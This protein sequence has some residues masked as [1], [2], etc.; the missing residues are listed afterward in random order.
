MSRDIDRILISTLP[1]SG[2]V[3]FFN[4]IAELFGYS[5]LEPRFTGGFRPKPPDWDPYIFDETYL[6][7]GPE[8]VLCAHYRLNADVDRLLERA[9]TLAIYLYRDPRDAAVSA[10]LYIKYGLTH[11]VL[12]K[13]FQEMSDGDAIAFMITGGVVCGDMFPDD[14]VASPLDHIHFDGMSHFI[15]DSY[16]WINDHRVLKIRYEDFFTNPLTLVELAREKDVIVDPVRVRAV[17]FGS[18]FKT[19]S[20]GR[21]IGMEDKSSHFRKGLIGDHKN[22]F[23][24]LHNALSRKYMGKW[25]IELG[26]ESN[27]AW[28]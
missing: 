13:P 19:A 22:L 5:K 15:N 2:T 26:Y 8:Q 7:L 12:H 24:S 4:F 10:A 1:R 11:H 9:D 27:I 16:A 17:T 14:M 18:D 25:L 21:P 3:F 20:G 23:S 6:D 28:L